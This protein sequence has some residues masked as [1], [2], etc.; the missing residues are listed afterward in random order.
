LAINDFPRFK[1]DLKKAKNILYIGD[2][3]GEIVFD[4]VF[5][6]ELIKEQKN[7]VFSVK[8]GPIIN[9]A[10][11]EDAEEAG[12]NNL[13]KVI[14]TGT[15]RSGVNFQYISEEFLK[16]FKKA[17][18]VISKGQAN[19]ECLDSVD[20]NTYFILKAKCRQVASCLK[21]GYL[22]VVLAKRRAAWGKQKI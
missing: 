19:F 4:R 11:R 15:D 18:L 22:D 3:A 10:T 9:D 13:V 21:A 6:E 14:E 12:I 7:I 16:E 8:S 20:K 2:N 17:D 1:A 5:L